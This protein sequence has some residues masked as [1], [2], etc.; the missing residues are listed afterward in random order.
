MITRRTVWF[1]G[2]SQLICWGIQYYLIGGI[3]EFIVADLGWSPT[4]VY[5][6]FSAAL[7]VMGLASSLIGRLIDEHGGRPVMVT[8]SCCAA[9]GCTGLALSQNLVSYYASWLVLGIAMRLTLYDAAFAALARI[10]GPFARRSMSQIT[11]LGGLSA[12]AFWPLGHF[13]AARF[14]WRGALFVYA[15]FALLTIPLHLAIPEGDFHA[16]A[17]GTTATPAPTPPART[18]GDRLLAGSL[19]AVTAVLT[20]FLNSAMS[21]HMIGILAGFG[22]AASLAVWIATLRGIGQSSARLA[23]VLF[24]SRLDPLMLNLVA[25][26]ILPLGFIVGLW[27]GT[28]AVAAVA[29][30]LCNG[31]GNGLV[32]ITRG[33]LPLVLFDPGRY[34]AT[35]GRLL[36]PSYFLSALAPLAY[37]LIIEHFGNPAT[38]HFST[39]IAAT[40]LVA[41][42]VLRWH[43]HESDAR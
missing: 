20:N 4:W 24:G 41:A 36:T 34:G 23:E 10:G 32:T 27:S 1:L 25:T 35:V 22:V 14:G 29:F 37:A 21:A 9:L 43:F 17:D 38:L 6:G 2:F 40:V 33:T 26:A 8:G 3:G 19:Y 5:G 16:S 18:R 15:G 31:A 7:V 42:I 30:A 13:L 39:A 11:L 12:S 28:S